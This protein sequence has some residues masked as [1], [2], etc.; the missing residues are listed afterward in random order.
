MSKAQIEVPAAKSKARRTNILPEQSLPS[1]SF[2]LIFLVLLFV[3]CKFFISYAIN[4]EDFNIYPCFL[5]LFCS[6]SWDSLML[7][8]LSLFVNALWVII[9]RG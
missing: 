1:V 9:Q 7:F 4:V 2:L 6:V 8:S 5:P 3:Y